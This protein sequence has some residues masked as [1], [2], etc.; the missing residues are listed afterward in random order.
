MFVQHPA[1]FIDDEPEDDEPKG[2]S[3][4]SSSKAEGDSQAEE[5]L[6]DGREI[7]SQS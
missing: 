7:D 3:E 4:S 1:D 5:E 2:G 6:Q